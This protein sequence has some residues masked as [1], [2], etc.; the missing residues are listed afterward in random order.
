MKIKPLWYAEVGGESLISAKQFREWF[1]NTPVK[2]KTNTHVFVP[3]HLVN[4]VGYRMGLALLR[5]TDW[6][7]RALPF[8]RKQGGLIQC[9][10][11]KKAN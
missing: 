4:M 9:Y 10:G 1:S 8:L 2:I 3:P 11:T 5:M 6:I 7:G